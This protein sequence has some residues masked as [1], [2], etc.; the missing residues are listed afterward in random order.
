MWSTQDFN[1]DQLAKIYPNP[2]GDLLHIASEAQAV[3]SVKIYNLLGQ[4]VQTAE[5][6]GRAKDFILEVSHLQSGHYLIRIEAGQSF[7]TQ[8]LT[9][10]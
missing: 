7:S 4:L 9:K 2:A 6:P 10:R 3:D 1:A 8:H 5:N